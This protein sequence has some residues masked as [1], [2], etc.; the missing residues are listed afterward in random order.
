[1]RS[2]DNYSLENESHESMIA[3]QRFHPATVIQYRDRSGKHE[4]VLHCGSQDH[5]RVFRDDRGTFVLSYN[6]H[7]DYVGVQVFSHN[8]QV[9]DHFVDQCGL[10]EMRT[11]G[12]FHTDW[13][14]Y[15]PISLLKILLQWW[16]D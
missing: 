10:D 8:D 14:Q 3:A 4:H 5:V 15:R 13:Y 16:Q 7:L 2:V 1:M 11:A 6:L 9:W 12:D